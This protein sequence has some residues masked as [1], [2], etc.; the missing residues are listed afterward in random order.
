[1]SHVLPVSSGFAGS[2]LTTASLRVQRQGSACLAVRA[3]ACAPAAA[4][5]CASPEQR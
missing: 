1:M 2:A 4:Y 3:P 5:S